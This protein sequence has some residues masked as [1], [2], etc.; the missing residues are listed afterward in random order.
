MHDLKLKGPE[1]LLIPPANRVGGAAASKKRAF[2]QV[3]GL[4]KTYLPL[5]VIVFVI[6]VKWFTAPVRSNEASAATA[7]SHAASAVGHPRVEAASH[8]PLQRAGRGAAA[9]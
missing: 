1:L 5:T 7:V 2:V 4:L 6:N 9:S 3:V 8:G